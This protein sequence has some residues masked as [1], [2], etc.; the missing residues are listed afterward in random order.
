[1]L[2]VVWAAAIARVDYGHLQWKASECGTAEFLGWVR[3]WG[4][5]SRLTCFLVLVI[6]L[7][8]QEASWNPWEIWDMYEPNQFR[9]TM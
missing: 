8:K 5:G 2:G 9:N 7:E 3:D 4:C 1:M 6:G